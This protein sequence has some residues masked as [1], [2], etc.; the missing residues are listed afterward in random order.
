VSYF[1][2]SSVNGAHGAAILKGGGTVGKRQCSSFDGSN[3]GREA[4]LAA[5]GPAPVSSGAIAIVV[6]AARDRA[7]PRVRRHDRNVS[8]FR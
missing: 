2:G 3:V 6:S 7:L 5:G 4:F 1:F 8:K